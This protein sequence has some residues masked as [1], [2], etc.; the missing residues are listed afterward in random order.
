[1]KQQPCLDVLVDVECMCA[2]LI[3]STNEHA[4]IP[5]HTGETPLG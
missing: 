4:G 5:T 3:M 2:H 1:M